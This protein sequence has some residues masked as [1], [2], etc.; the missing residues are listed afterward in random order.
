MQG[1]VTTPRVGGQ[2]EEVG[3]IT[4]R[5][6]KE[7]PQRAG[8]QTS[9]GVTKRNKTCFLTSKAWLRRHTFASKIP[10]KI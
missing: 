4:T 5:S 10:A 3:S 7:G 2:K 6:L 8:T 1:T 9:E